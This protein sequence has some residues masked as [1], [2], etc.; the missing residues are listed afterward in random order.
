MI[1]KRRRFSAAAVI[2]AVATAVVLSHCM[3]FLSSCGGAGGS[4]SSGTP[5]PSVPTF[6]VS[7]SPSKVTLAQGG[8]T[9]IQVSVQAQNGFSKAVTVAVGEFPGGVKASPASTSVQPGD[10]ANVTLSAAT[11]AAIAQQA[12][13]I[14]AVSGQIIVDDYVPLSVTG[15]PVREPY[16]P[17]GGQVVHGFYD[18]ARQLLFVSNPGLNEIDVLS[19]QT[20][21][22]QAR[23]PAQQPWGMDQMADGNTLVVGTAAQQILTMDEDTLAITSHPYAPTG[24]TSPSLFFVNVVALANGK[25]LMIGQE[26]GIDSDNI[27]EA[28][29]TL[30][31]WDSNTDTFSQFPV[32]QPVPDNIDTIARS[33]DHKWAAFA[34][35][36][37]Y[38]YSS[39]SD[40]VQ[41]VPVPVADPSNMGVRGLAINSDGSEI[42][43]VSGISITFLD[44][45][46]TGLHN[47]SIPSAFPSAGTVQFSEDDS[48]LY[49]SYM[50]PIIEEVDPK[51][52]TA[53]GYVIG[54]GAPGGLTD[55]M[56]ASDATGHGFMANGGA[57]QVVNL[58]GPL[59]RNAN[60]AGPN[61]SVTP[62]AF[63]AGVVSK[64]PISPGVPNPLNQTSYYLAGEPIPV[65]SDGQD[66][67]VTPPAN[68]GP[69][70]IECIGTTGLTYEF[71]DVFSFGV[72]TIGFSANLL[73]PT[74]NPPVYVFGYGFS[75]SFEPNLAETPKVSIGGRAA[76]N[77][78]TLTDL[79]Y[80]ALFG[81]QAN[82]P[83]GTAGSS[84]SVEVSSSLGSS[85]LNGAATYYAA[86]K[87]IPASGLLQ[88]LNDTHRNLIY[89]LKAT[90]VD[91]LNPS[92]LQW[93]A[94]LPLPQPTPAVSYGVMALSPDGS[95]LVIASDD[96]H[97]VVMNPA[98]PSQATL[99]YWNKGFEGFGFGMA[100]TNSNKVLFGGSIY[101]TELDLSTST[102][103]SLTQTAGDV[104]RA[105]ADGSHIYGVSINNSGGGVYSIDP[106]TFAVQSETFGESFWN[107]L[108]V[109]ANGSQF[110]TVFAPPNQIGSA[111]GF[112]DSGLHYVNTNL[113]PDFSPADDT[114]VPG[115]TYSPGGKVLVVALGDSIEFWDAQ[116]G[117]L[118]ARLMTAEELSVLTYPEPPVAPRLVL[119]TTGQ[120]IYVISASGLMVIKLPQPMDQMTPFPW[121]PA[122]VLGGQQPWLHGTITSRM[123]AT[124]KNIER[125]LSR[126]RAK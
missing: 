94:P 11:Y 75:A 113:Y 63:P 26:Q 118:R 82:A 20:Y 62:T 48:R 30:Y 120:I 89:A 73:P 41:S 22:V 45:S 111:V 74:G 110:A 18:D 84:V 97:V 38:L 8:T 85:T 68:Q 103:S 69:A 58:L 23:V 3:V 119:D 77:V 24:S 10:S 114:G 87:I 46:L 17:V 65:L 78:G 13:H 21:A 104:I 43:V 49:V 112:F 67:S 5:T 102:F 50:G 61:C 4:S 93:Q 15:E 54:Q 51:S 72:D 99:L 44:N 116:Q 37:F 36:E 64:L 29:Q 121:P 80:G 106:N 79:E 105:S 91:V 76:S 66:L 19:G 31:E 108:A 53:L 90:E 60:M 96:G 107:D 83:D 47:T 124:R 101:P 27:Y 57:V 7:V 95:Q 12:M 100:I 9:Q 98:Q 81:A 39:D 71:A 88:L 126:A 55:K 92:T 34:F 40:S 122:V 123:M 52:F 14:H 1:P 56:L 2:S 86:P 35:D 125:E 6:T 42:A 115:A 70:D 28:G 109:N 59:G 32:P 25:V 33:K 117:T 16:H